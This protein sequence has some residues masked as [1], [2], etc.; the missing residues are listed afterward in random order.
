VMAIALAIAITALG[1]W[2]ARN[3][4]KSAHLVEGP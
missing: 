3:A 1:W 4:G 2:F